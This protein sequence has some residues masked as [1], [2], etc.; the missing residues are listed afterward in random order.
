M[1][2]NKASAEELEDAQAN[3]EMDESS[4]EEFENELENKSIEKLSGELNEKI[5]DSSIK[6]FGYTKENSYSNENE[7]VVK[8]VIK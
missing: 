3:D 7:F 1:E 5:K 8:E 2:T 4:E 6:L